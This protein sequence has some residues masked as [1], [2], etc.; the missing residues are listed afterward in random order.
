MIERMIKMNKFQ[1]GGLVIG[2]VIILALVLSL[3]CLEVVKP[4]YAGIVYNKRGGIERDTISQGWHFISPMK[5]VIKYPVSTETVYLSADKREGSEENESFLVPSKDGKQIRVGIEFNY[6]YDPEML[7]QVFVKFRGRKP[8]EIERTFISGK[9]KAWS[10]ESTALYPV[11]GLYGE[12]R[13]EAGRA[14]HELMKDRFAEWGIVVENFAFIEVLPDE[15]S[16]Q[17]IQE[18]VDAAQKLETAKIL[19]EQTKVESETKRIQA[20][21]TAD[22]ALIVAESEAKANE[23]LNKFLTDKVI[24]KL[25]IEK[26]DGKKPMVEGGNPFLYP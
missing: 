1:A 19:Q 14:A 12:K 23:L 25:W 16:L 24:L 13:A 22:A 20:Q 5:E 3:L 10:A 4:G 17:A 7:P 15:Q 18:R 6:H 9:I 21:A 8:S 26:W 11:I 2:I